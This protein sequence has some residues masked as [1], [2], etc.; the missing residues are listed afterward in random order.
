M[1]RAFFSQLI[2]STK[3]KYKNHAKIHVNKI[4]TII[5]QSIISVN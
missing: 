1:K 4:R 3:K 2:K 5:N